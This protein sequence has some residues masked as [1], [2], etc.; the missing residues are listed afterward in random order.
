MDTPASSKTRTAKSKPEPSGFEQWKRRAG[1]HKVTTKSGQPIEFRLMGLGE[2]TL[3]GLLPTQLRELVSLD[4]LNKAQGGIAA[5]I[6]DDIVKA[7]DGPEQQE[8]LDRHLS[9][10]YELNKHLVAA[11]LVEPPLTVEQL[12]EIPFEDLEE[13]VRLITGQQPFDSR[14]VRV[15]VEPLDTFARFHHH[16]KLGPV[17]GC[18]GCAD[19]QHDFSS[20][21]LGAL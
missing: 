1:P 7:V 14:G 4:V 10:L 3:R 19:L 12:A 18:Q 21:H 5:V 17:A 9:E 16:H 2:L 20:L 15:G 13:C 6:A 8:T 11:A